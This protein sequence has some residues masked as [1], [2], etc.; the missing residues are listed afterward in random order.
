MSG[1]HWSQPE[2]LWLLWLLPLVFW[3]AMR[4]HGR[5]RRAAERFAGAPMAAR[6]MP[7]LRAGPVAL[8]A[9]VASLALALGILALARPGWGYD[10]IPVK[11][12]GVDMCVALDLSRSMLADDGGESRLDRAKAALAALIEDMEGDRVGLIYFAGEVLRAAPLTFDRGFLLQALRQASPEM[13]GRGGTLIGPALE[14]AG[15]MLDGEGGRDQVVVLVTDAG[16]QDSFPETAAAELGRRGIRVL[17]AG[18]G[19]TDGG[20]DAP[21][22]LDG[23]VVRRADGTP[24]PARV[25]M[26][27]LN[28]IIQATR[29]LLVPPGQIHRLKD[30]YRRYVDPL[31]K[32]SGAAFEERRAIDRYRWFL[33][34]SILAW[35][36]FFW[37]R[38]YPA[39]RSAGG[40]AVLALLAL[41]GGCGADP[42]A[43]RTSE[44]A[45]LLGAGDPEGAEALFREVEAAR[46]D[47]PA[48]A[49]NVGVA[50][51]VRGDGEAAR[52]AF[53]RAIEQGGP[54]IRA[55]AFLSLARLDVRDLQALVPSGLARAGAGERTAL[56]RAAE[57]V[58]DRY[59]MAR[60]LDP[61]LVEAEE[62]QAR[63]ALWLRRAEDLWAA[64]DLEAARRGRAALSG[65]ALLE[66]LMDEARDALSRMAQGA[67]LQNVALVFADLAAE[68]DRL[69]G[70][71]SQEDPGIAPA[72]RDEARRLARELPGSLALV[73]RALEAEDLF[74]VSG[75][76]AKAA[77][78]A[79]RLHALWAEP[80]AVLDRLAAVLGPAALDLS[81]E[82]AG[83]GLDGEGGSA[84][85]AAALEWSERLSSLDGRLARPEA[86]GAGA[87]RFVESARKRLPPAVR[88]L[89]AFS[90]LRPPDLAE[91]P[92]LLAGV[93]QD[94]DLLRRE[95]MLSRLSA[96]RLALELAQEAR[97]LQVLLASRDVAR[98]ANLPGAPAGPVA[99][100]R[101]RCAYLMPAVDR[102]LS[103][104]AD[105]AG[106]GEEDAGEVAGRRAVFEALSAQVASALSGGADLLESEGWPPAGGVAP[107]LAEARTGLRRI[108]ALLATFDEL[109]KDAAAA[110]SARAAAGRAAAE[111]AE[112]EGGSP[113]ADLGA[114]PLSP[115]DQAGEQRAVVEDIERLAAAAPALKEQIRSE[116]GGEEASAADSEEAAARALALDAVVQHL[117]RAREAAALAL[118]GLDAAA[119]RSDPAGMAA[120]LRDAA[121]RQ[122]LAAAE[123]AAAA[124]AWEEALM[125]L[126]LLARR[127][128][129]VAESMLPALREWAAGR[130]PLAA[131]PFDPAGAAEGL[132]ALAGGWVDRLRPAF[133][134]ERKAALDRADQAGGEG[135]AGTAED[136]AA[137]EAAVGRA[138]EAYGG[139]R[140][141][142]DAGRPALARDAA[143]SL[144]GAARDLWLPFAG[145]EDLLETGIAGQAALRDRAGAMGD[146]PEPE[147]ADR[148]EA[149][150]ADQE[151][152]GGLIPFME[153]AVEAS[154]PEEEGGL[155]G[156][157]RSLAA[158]NLPAAGEAMADAA[159]AVA[160][161]RYP[162]GRQR[163][164]TARRLL[165]E[166]LDRLN[167]DRNGGGEQDRSRE[168]PEPGPRE[169]DGSRMESLDRL[170][171]AVEERNRERQRRQTPEQPAVK[172][173]W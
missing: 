116:A 136:F 135:G 48:A 53:G 43:G 44:A 131:M 150:S 139:L 41:L 102:A 58:L 83:P 29:G 119:V 54:W 68:G 1:L 74:A 70:E 59:Q 69:S 141:A 82:G 159:A 6:I 106:G 117:D 23:Q 61:D 62:E 168:A 169:E 100:L 173:D 115:A 104:A 38:P 64:A 34:P 81:Q 47:E 9:C 92:A 94:V 84:L 18:V 66:A 80:G 147:P 91:G 5:V 15:A 101:D 52:R 46:K 12:R 151:F 86:E 76:A 134:R 13:V 155:S 161:R 114:P 45:R 89:A 17:A 99:L 172:E 71:V 124:K 127:L 42:D 138:E 149:W 163:A 2:A 85:R 129:S 56:R 170:R 55:R 167:R 122:E 153:R 109:L 166:I 28:Q 126:P 31:K 145:L 16:D 57:G 49:F 10:A 93:A 60:R 72:D 75:A 105:A 144:R 164:E 90:G 50:A 128:L 63:V 121:G 110:Q 21:L 39:A 108:W 33:L 22:V 87:E 133:A 65:V 73:A 11:A 32:E 97:G 162:A 171:R 35:I 95:W 132:G 123:L 140:S 88:D 137:L 146:E 156:E 3:L 120:G 112:A 158:E 19:R 103:E 160:E 25:H 40:G 8:R 51:A 79:H 4:S 37:M 20:D 154:P 77:A 78:V 26:D 165:E 30:L 67:L 36:A 24:V 148:I 27:L 7:P 96:S 111:A 143:A 125:P 14:A 113:G 107:A 98:W 152:A 157:A 142:L 130:E 118:S